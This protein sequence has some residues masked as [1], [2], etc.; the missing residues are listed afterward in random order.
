M[1]KQRAAVRIGRTYYPLPKGAATPETL[2]EARDLVSQMPASDYCPP[3]WALVA[4]FD[5]PGWAGS[6]VI[7]LVLK[8]DDRVSFAVVPDD[9]DVDALRTLR[10]LEEVGAQRVGWLRPGMY[11][12]GTM[13]IVR[14][15]A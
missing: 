2:E 6:R 7:E 1:G 12:V 14:G 8:P 13:I 5:W 3:S 9:V 4:E 15:G 11:R 10:D